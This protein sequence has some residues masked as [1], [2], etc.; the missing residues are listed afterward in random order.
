MYSYISHISQEFKSEDFLKFVQ[1]NGFEETVE[2]EYK[3]IL[4][5]PMGGMFKESQKSE[6]VPLNRIR[7]PNCFDHSRVV[8]PVEKERGD[9]ING[10]YVDGY[11]Q[12]K[13]FICMQAPMHHTNYDLWRTVWM[14]HSRIIVMLCEKTAFNRKIY[15]AYWCHMKGTLK[16]GKFEVQTKKIEVQQNYVKSTL[17]VTDG[18]GAS[19]EVLHFAFTTWPDMDLPATVDDFLD[20]VL[21]VRRDNEIIKKRLTQEG[22]QFHNP[23]IIVHS[24]MGVNRSGVF[25]AIEIEISRFNETGL[26]SLASTV[27][28]IREQRHN[29][30]SRFT[31]YIFCYK[32]LAKYVSTVG[33]PNE[34]SLKLVGSYFLPLFKNSA[35][36][37]FFSSRHGES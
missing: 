17:E 27:T 31:S 6:N 19:Q 5:K 16:C 2:E 7:Y 9:Y 4:R 12:T 25:C 15:D 1:Q 33:P 37:N 3:T 8:L 24:E 26:I 13:K 36:S 21:A 29:A 18:T 23:S 34:N 22:C 32:V 30:V 35:V 14:N 20:F 28:R 11:N 10:N